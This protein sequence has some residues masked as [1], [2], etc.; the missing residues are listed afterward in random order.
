[1]VHL[2]RKT[3]QGLW[4]IQRD[5]GHGAAFFKGHRQSAVLGHGQGLL[6]MS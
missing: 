6:L 5:Q 3:V 4:A 2:T 1:M